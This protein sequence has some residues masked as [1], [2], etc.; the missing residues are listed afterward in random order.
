MALSQ[1]HGFIT[2]NRLEARA[3]YDTAGAAKMLAHDRPKA[4]AAIA[5]RYAAE[6]YGLEVLKENI[7][8]HPGNT[9]RFVVVA[10][11]RLAQAGDKCSLCFSTA[12][13]A[14]ALQDVLKLFSEAG[15]NLTRIES[16]PDRD[17]PGSFLF[18]LDLIGSDA[19]PKVAQALAK[20]KERTHR[21][22][23]LGCFKEA[24]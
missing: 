22:R 1:C 10:R 20:V 21:Y 19:E 24:P 12:H 3:F 6:L 9:T 17:A 8:D 11:E 14:G 18:V 2:R 5:S 13:K 7:E 23:L 4:A 16:I 15:I